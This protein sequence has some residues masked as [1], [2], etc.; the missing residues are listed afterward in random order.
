MIAIGIFAILQALLIPGFLLIYALRMHHGVLRAIILSAAISPLINLI[1]VYGLVL[2]HLYSPIA[3]LI[4]ILFELC[5]FLWIRRKRKTQYIYFPADEY[6]SSFYLRSK[7]TKDFS[8]L[9]FI[10]LIIFIVFLTIYLNDFFASCYTALFSR[11]AVISFFGWALELYKGGLPIHVWDYPQLLSANWSLILMITRQPNLEIFLHIFVASFPILILLL[12]IDLALRKKS[13]I[14]IL[15]ATIAAFLYF[16][17]NHFEGNFNSADLACAFFGFTSFYLVFTCQ[18]EKKIKNIATITYLGAL[19]ASSAALAKQSG[20]YVAIGYPFFAY[21]M[22]LKKH[23][24]T[25]TRNILLRMLLILI[26]LIFPFYL[27]LELPVLLNKTS[28]S[29]NFMLHQLLPTDILARPL[30]FYHKFFPAIYN[31]F[32]MLV[33]LPFFLVIGLLKRSIYRNIFLAYVLPFFLIWLFFFSYDPRNLAIIIPFIAITAG[34]GITSALNLTLKLLTTSKEITRTYAKWLLSLLVFALLL[35]GISLHYNLNYLIVDQLRQRL[36]VGIIQVN[37]Y[38]LTAYQKNPSAVTIL[39]NAPYI[40]FTPLYYS[41][42]TTDPLNN[43]KIIKHI[44]QNKKPH[45]M[46]IVKLLLLQSR[47]RDANFNTIT[48]L[49]A[50]GYKKYHVAQYLQKEVFPL[51]PKKYKVIYNTP[52]YLLI[53]LN[54]PVQEKHKKVNT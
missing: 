26:G 3:M 29:Y 48:Q 23:P 9:H 39:T 6:D 21:Y 5:L 49:T 1:I 17:N 27:Q 11:D 46:M 19:I 52:E 53:Q 51:F 16:L 4:L 41:K 47:L 15:S 24:L 13:F 33:V 31:K 30:Y 44:L 28:S 40:K 38:L 18:S 8:F 42:T 25:D 14:Y 10:F 7:W 54:W 50:K 12:F 34:T 32:L 45:Y 43:P 2:T 36:N 20:I 22:L 37:D 35:C